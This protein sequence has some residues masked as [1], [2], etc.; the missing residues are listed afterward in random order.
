MKK[1]K[2]LIPLTIL[3]AFSLAGCEVSDWLTS[4]FNSQTTES[5]EN[6]DFSNDVLGTG[7]TVEVEATPDE[8]VVENTDD[9]SLSTSDGTFEQAVSLYTITAAGTYNVSGVLEDGQILINAGDE[10]EVVLELNGATISCSTDS[11]IKAMNA[12]KL[13]ISAKKNTSN[14]IYDNRSSKTV[15]DDSQGEG[16]VYA[17]CDFKLKGAGTLVV[18]GNYNNGLHTTKDLTIQK[19]TLYVYGYNN[20]IKGNDSVTI[21]SGAV[22]AISKTGN[23]IKTENTD[24]SSKSKQRGS[25]NFNGGSILVDS[26]CDA[27]EAAYDVVVNES[28]EDGLTTSITL[29]TGQYCQN[30]SAYNKNTVNSS[31]GLKAENTISVE[32]G[33]VVI[34]ASDDSVH[35]NYGTAIESGGTGLGNINISGGSVSIASGDDGIHADNTL[36]I[37]GGEV[38]VTNS[39]EGLEAN[40]III[41]GGTSR[42]YASNDGVN[43]SNK[44][45]Q[46]PTI[47]VSGGVLD[48]SIASGDTDGIDS[49]GTFSQTGG[50]IISRGSPNTADGMSTGLDCDVSAS[51]SGG[52]FIAFNGLEKQP[53]VGSG[54]VKAYYGTSTQGGGPGGGGPG[55]GHRATYSSKFQSGTYTLSGGDFSKEFYNQFTYSTFIVYSSEM[56]TGTAYTLVNGD[57]TILSWTQSSSNQQ[58]S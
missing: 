37:S 21:T 44:I 31:K 40:H 36:T 2:F 35:A 6:L 52:T 11:P 39:F 58:I 1:L 3:S 25:I 4:V 48:V 27:V 43:A 50:L 34:Q 57:S 26:L 10:D 15:D 12:G 56:S 28:N 19:E 13:E 41:E 5:G 55:G 47:V 33:T 16:A 18:K 30:S 53:T 54:V 23:G 20:A 45:N 29:K 49:N 42:V 24:L 7:V 51:I 32:S 9:F 22:T 46:T 38:L 8:P 14:A 17:K